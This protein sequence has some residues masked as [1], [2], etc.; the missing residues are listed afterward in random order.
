[1][2]AGDVNI[3]GPYSISA[4]QWDAG[5][6]GNVVVADLLVPVYS[7]NGLQVHFVVVKAA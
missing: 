1:M 3:F 2:A 7:A 5:L 4:G 6:T